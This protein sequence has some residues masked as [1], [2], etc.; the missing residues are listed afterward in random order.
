MRRIRHV[1]LALLGTL[2][3]FVLPLVAHADPIRVT[4]GAATVYSPTEISGATLSNDA[5]FFLSGDGFGSLSWAGGAPGE[6]RKLDGSFSFGFTGPFGAHIDGTSYVA[7]LSGSLDFLTDAFVLPGPGQDGVG[8]F[9][10][11]FSMTGRV[12]GYSS[13][14]RDPGS[15]LFDVELF[16]AGVAQASPVFVPSLNAYQPLFA[17]ATYNFAPADLSA[18]PEPGSLLL[19][20]TGAVGL[21]LRN[22]RQ[23]KA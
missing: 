2:C 16:G 13:V 3:L 19:L 9:S 20:G 4:G 15:L 12:Q 18:T 8:H 17:S 14:Q 23:R 7:Y 5:G 6:T 21:V 1:R 10:T 11:P 22:R